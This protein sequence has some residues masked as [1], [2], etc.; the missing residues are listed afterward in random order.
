MKLQ[1]NASRS[2]RPLAPRCRNGVSSLLRLAQ[3]SAPR[4]PQPQDISGW[5]SRAAGALGIARSSSEP[6]FAASRF[7]AG[8]IQ[9]F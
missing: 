6:A 4:L 8:P 2:P 9:M 7:G 5:V 3:P 1:R